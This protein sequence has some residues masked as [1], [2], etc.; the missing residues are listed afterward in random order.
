MSYLVANSGILIT[1]SQILEHC[2]DYSFESYDR[3]VDTHIKNMRSKMGSLGSQWIE[4][5]RGYGYRFAGR[6][7]GTPVSASKT[8]T[9]PKNGEEASG[10]EG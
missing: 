8:V 7:T 10:H 9:S 3:I 2:F 6:G 5:V 4:T 1:R